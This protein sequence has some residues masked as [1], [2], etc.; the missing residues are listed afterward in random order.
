MTHSR[1]SGTSTPG[2]PGGHAS[3][4]EPASQNGDGSLLV[5]T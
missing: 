4:D 5:K 3:T 2:A 1:P